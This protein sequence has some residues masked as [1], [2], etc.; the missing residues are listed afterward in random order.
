[1]VR[2]YAGP[3]PPSVMDVTTDRAGWVRQRTFSGKSARVTSSRHRGG[4]DE[5][6]CDIAWHIDRFGGDGVFSPSRFLH[7]L[8]RR[9]PVSC[10]GAA[11]LPVCFLRVGFIQSQPPADERCRYDTCSAARSR[12]V[13]T[14]LSGS[15][16]QAGASGR[17]RGTTRAARPVMAAATSQPVVLP[18]PRL[19]APSP[20]P[21]RV[22][23]P[24]MDPPKTVMLDP[25]R[26]EVTAVAPRPD[27][28]S[29][30]AQRQR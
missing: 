7:L 2:P 25:P 12:A 13:A 27:E 22:E 5:A 17:R 24:R 28:T 4:T 23:L 8:D 26:M 18:P 3:V 30:I 6:A 1:M 15:S 11:E 9:P 10:R 20:N 19:E 21:P 16:G 14:G 29:S